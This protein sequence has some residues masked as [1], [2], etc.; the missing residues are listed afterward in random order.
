M[1]PKESYRVARR[2]S[3]YDAS[4]EAEGLKRRWPS[5]LTRWMKIPG[6]DAQMVKR[7]WNVP[8]SNAEDGNMSKRYATWMEAQASSCRYAKLPVY[9]HRPVTPSRIWDTVMRDVLTERVEQDRDIS[10]TPKYVRGDRTKVVLPPAPEYAPVRTLVRRKKGN[11]DKFLYGFFPATVHSLVQ[12]AYEPPQLWMPEHMEEAALSFGPDDWTSSEVDDA[13][14]ELVGDDDWWETSKRTDRDGQYKPVRS[15]VFSDPLVQ[16]LHAEG[17]HDE[18]VDLCS[19]HRAGFAHN[20]M[21]LYME[22]R[23]DRYPQT[24]PGTVWVSEGLNETKAVKPYVRARRVK[25]A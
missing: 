11:E 16:L 1:T 3:R 15:E 14:L 2:S 20:S 4:K 24:L 7:S 10:Y 19:M 12:W 5:L 21:N 18:A 22:Q 25:A 6:L 8:F 9:K 23:P 13:A 17:S